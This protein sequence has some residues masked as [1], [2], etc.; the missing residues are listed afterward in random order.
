[1]PIKGPEVMPS[2]DLQSINM[3]QQAYALPTRNEESTSSR[4]RL[5]L[6]E[7]DELPT[8]LVERHELVTSPR[9][10]KETD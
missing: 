8:K 7:V 3:L 1:M 9:E 6:D 5:N 2:L 10:R 4:P